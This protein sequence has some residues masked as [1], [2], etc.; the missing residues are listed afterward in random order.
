MKNIL[1]NKDALGKKRINYLHLTDLIING[2]YEI[3]MN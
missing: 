3:S 2:S 1:K